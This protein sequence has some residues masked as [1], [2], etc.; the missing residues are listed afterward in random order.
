MV[1]GSIPLIKATSLMV[2]ICHRLN[3]FCMAQQAK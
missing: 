3:D 1:F 2:A